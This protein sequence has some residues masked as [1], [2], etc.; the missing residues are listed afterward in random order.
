MSV[1][2]LLI[3]FYS[4][5]VFVAVILSWIP[6]AYDNVLGRAIARVTEPV[7]G[8]IRTVIPPLGGFDLSPML[9]LIALRA[10]R[11]LIL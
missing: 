11:S 4:F 7:F 1:L 8:L 2:A 10:V 3:D 6:G 5:I 9:L